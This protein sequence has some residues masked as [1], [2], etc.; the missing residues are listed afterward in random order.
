MAEIAKKTKPDMVLFACIDEQE[1]KR[2]IAENIE[3]IQ[4]ELS[5]LGIDVKWYKLEHVDYSL[6]V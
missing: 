5:P 1:P 2:R 3:R 4:N 6:G